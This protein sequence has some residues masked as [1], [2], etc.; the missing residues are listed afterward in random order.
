MEVEL[1]SSQKNQ[2]WSLIPKSSIQKLI[3]SKWIYKIKPGT[4][5][6]SKPRYKIK[7]VAKILSAYRSKYQLD[8]LKVK[9]GW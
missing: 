7:L 3:Q 1:F 2:T 9:S 8:E 4:R 5:G 6:V